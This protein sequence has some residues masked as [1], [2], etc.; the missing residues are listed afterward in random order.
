[1]S[2]LQPSNTDAIL[3]GQNPPPL[4]AAVLGGVA[5]M[6]RQI[7][8]EWRLNEELA[9]ELSETHEIDSFETVILNDRDEVVRH[10]KKHA[11]YYTESLG[12]DVT[13]DMTYIPAGSFMM[14][15]TEEQ[16]DSYV[17]DSKKAQTPQHLVTLS[18]F[19]M[20]KY[21]I[22]QKQYQ[23]IMGENPS[24]FKGNNRPV[25]TVPWHRAKDFCQKLSIKTG[26]V[27]T[28]P[29]E[30]QWEYACRAGSTTLFYCGDNI[31][32]EIANYNGNSH[33][34]GIIKR[35]NRKETTDVNLFNPNAFGLYDMHGNVIQWCEDT[36]HS[37]YKGAPTNGESWIEDLPA[38]RF[39]DYYY[40]VLRGGS[41]STGYMGC[42]SSSRCTGSNIPHIVGLRVVCIP[43]QTKKF[44]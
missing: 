10:A 20:G 21:P 13:I 11:F 7:V 31:T 5:G 28:L 24:Y 9:N 18:A 17:D 6:K 26:K 38:W 25:E 2:E 22:T 12:N 41:W 8:S 15:L 37:N 40:H 42:H 4:N 33:G 39:G 44:Q 29:S 23:H 34:E 35:I 32:T 43:L 30:S 1:M 36:W 19:H 16:N 14:G 3:G 27:Y